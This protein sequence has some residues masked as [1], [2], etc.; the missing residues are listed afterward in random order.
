MDVLVQE[1]FRPYEQKLLQKLN[2]VLNL[3]DVAG[4]I[5][6]NI[7]FFSDQRHYTKEGKRGLILG[8]IE[9]DFEIQ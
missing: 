9:M 2:K 4:V 7:Y 8:R 3:K 1:Q 5:K 6:E